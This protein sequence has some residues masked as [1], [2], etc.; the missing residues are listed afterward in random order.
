MYAFTHS[1]MHFKRLN[2][3]YG[4]E[5]SVGQ[6]VTVTC[7]YTINVCMYIYI[8]THVCVSVSLYHAK[9]STDALS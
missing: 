3:I 2:I 1:D 5:A 6:E 4:H 8:Y 7:I 9:L